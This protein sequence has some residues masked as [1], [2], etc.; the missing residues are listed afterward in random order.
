MN[1]CPVKKLCHKNKKRNEKGKNLIDSE[2]V[3]GR[4]N[5]ATIERCNGFEKLL[6]EGSSV[7]GFIQESREKR[8]LGSPFLIRW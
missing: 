4:G 5:S 2:L 1:E 7:F 3:I 8:H 6:L